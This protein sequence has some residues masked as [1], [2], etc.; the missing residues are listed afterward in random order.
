MDPTT[1]PPPTDFPLWKEALLVLSGALL[2]SWKTIFRRHEKQNDDEAETLKKHS[3]EMAKLTARVMLIESKPA[4]ITVSELDLAIERALSRAKDL[5]TPQHDELAKKAE[6]AIEQSKLE[7]Q[8]LVTECNGAI[9]RDL[10]GSIDK[11]REDVIPSL[12]AVTAALQQ[13][14][15]LMRQYSGLVD[16]VTAALSE[17]GL[18]RRKRR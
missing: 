18:D 2:A 17:A 6:R 14:H 7:T 4:S 9:R 15:E 16:R 1:T 3:E 8:H 12:N 5:F 11:L 10:G 13:S